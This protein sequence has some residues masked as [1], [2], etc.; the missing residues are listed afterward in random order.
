[1]TFT[2]RPA[3]V[4]S[5]VA[6]LR[7]YVGEYLSPAGAVFSVQLKDNGT[8][9]VQQPG[10]PFQPLVPFKP[11]TFKIREFSDVTVRFEVA[12]GKVVTLIRSDPSGEHRNPRKE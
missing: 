7:R 12:G 1:M 4:L 6:T 5:E 11:H 2:R 8:L 10:Q 9:G 3:A